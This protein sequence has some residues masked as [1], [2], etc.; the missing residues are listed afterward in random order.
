MMYIFMLFM[1]ATGYYTLTY[2]ISMFRDDK[3]KLGGIATMIF[4][5]VGT[6]APIIVM[7][8]KQ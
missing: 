1:L 2:G 5:V 8:I 3:N 6:I 4:V 7:L